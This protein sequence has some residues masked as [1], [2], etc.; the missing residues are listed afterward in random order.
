M[1]GP[2]LD[3]TGVISDRVSKELHTN[4]FPIQAGMAPRLQRPGVAAGG[5]PPRGVREV[6]GPEPSPP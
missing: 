4:R 6:P 2:G 3:R 1:E 5:A